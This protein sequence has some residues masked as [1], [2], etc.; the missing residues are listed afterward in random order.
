MSVLKIKHIDKF[1]VYILKAIDGA[2]IISVE[3]DNDVT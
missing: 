1:I 2:N 3:K